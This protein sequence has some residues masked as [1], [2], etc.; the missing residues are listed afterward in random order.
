[1]GFFWSQEDNLLK[2]AIGTDCEKVNLFAI[3]KKACGTD[4]EKVNLFAIMKT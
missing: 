2:K 1:M 4:Y 3:M